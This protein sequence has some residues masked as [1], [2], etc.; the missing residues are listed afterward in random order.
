MLHTWD[1]FEVVACKGDAWRWE[2]ILALRD[3]VVSK[4]GEVS[5]TRV[6]FSRMASSFNI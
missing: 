6:C 4:L 2:M 3:E 5:A 1:I